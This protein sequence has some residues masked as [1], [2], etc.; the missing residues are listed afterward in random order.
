MKEIID[1]VLAK[2]DKV[3]EK[4]DKLGDT[5]T[6]QEENLKEHMRRTALLES[7]LLP[8]REFQSQLRGIAKF[9][10]AMSFL[11]GLVYTILQLKGI[12]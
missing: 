7:Q 8:I 3:D 12:I 2:L 11:T 4:L 9:I 1:V 10:G 6:K 5:V